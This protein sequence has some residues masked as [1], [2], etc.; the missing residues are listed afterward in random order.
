M[1][2]AGNIFEVSKSEE[3][4]SIYNE[5]YNLH[6]DGRILATNPLSLGTIIKN[7]NSSF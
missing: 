2:L 4:R 6:L 7:D 1:Y 5:G 3:K